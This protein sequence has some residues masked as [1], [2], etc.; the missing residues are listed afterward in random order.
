[1]RRRSFIFTERIN[2]TLVLYSMLKRCLLLA[3]FVSVIGLDASEC[4]ISD[5]KSL[6]HQTANTKDTSATEKISFFAEEVVGTRQKLSLKTDVEMRY[7][8][9]TIRTD[10]AEY[11]ASTGTLTT[12]NKVSLSSEQGAITGLT[13][14]FDLVEQTANF[15]NAEFEFS[16]GTRG[17]AGELDLSANGVQNLK[18]VRFSGCPKDHTGWELIAPDISLDQNK[19]RGYARK[20][21]L[22][23]ANVLLLYLPYFSFPL[24]NQRKS[25]FLMPNIGTSNKS[26]LE[27]SIPYYWNIRPNLDATLTPR[28]LTDRGLQLENE[29]R[30]LLPYSN[31]IA[32]FDILFNDKKR[33]SS[34]HSLNI[35]N[36]LEFGQNWDLDIDISDVSDNNYFVD[37]GGNLNKTAITNLNRELNLSYYGKVWNIQGLIQDYQ[38]ID[39]RIS[40][41]NEPYQRL[42]QITT[43]ASW[44]QSWLAGLSVDLDTELV[45]F[46]RV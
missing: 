16:D 13:A 12:P 7:Q 17:S 27:M 37:F 21:R 36:R 14:D 20:M 8:G 28:W 26:G 41:F 45:N 24:N 9:Q 31:G 3:A 44:P 42:P 10:I 19:Q 1:M 40:N 15:K 38:V 22:E 34:R 5:N 4:A 29:F 6:T 30:H 18:Q 11:D 39:P 46:R 23:F 33:S 43:Q 2:T 25:G 32:K 35:L